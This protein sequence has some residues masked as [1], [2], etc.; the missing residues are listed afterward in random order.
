MTGEAGAD[1]EIKRERVP[2]SRNS[3]S[4]GGLGDAVSPQWVQGKAL[5]GVQGAKALEALRISSFCYPKN[6]LKIVF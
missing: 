2:S 3:V 1:L 5:L 4:T 6:T